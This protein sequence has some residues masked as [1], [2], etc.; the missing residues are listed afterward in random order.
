MLELEFN[1]YVVVIIQANSNKKDFKVYTNAHDIKLTSNPEIDSNIVKGFSIETLS[2][3]MY[4][5]KA[6]KP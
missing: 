2:N 1:L 3:I 4:K 6:Y 5:N